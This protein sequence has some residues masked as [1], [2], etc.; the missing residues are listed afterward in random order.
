MT[1]IPIKNG[2]LCVPN[3]TFQKLTLEDGQ[4][5]WFEDNKNFGP[6]FWCDEDCTN[7]F[8]RWWDNEELSIFVD[9]Y[10]PRNKG[11]HDDL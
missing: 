6:F 8:E 11:E 7:E 9:D 5:V 10:Y 3:S 4:E 1:C 2:F